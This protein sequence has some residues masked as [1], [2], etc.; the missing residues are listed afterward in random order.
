MLNENKD[1]EAKPLGHG[2]DMQT[3]RW[4]GF[5]RPGFEER[6]ALGEQGLSQVWILAVRLFQVTAGLTVTVWLIRS[7]ED[8]DEAEVT[9]PL[10]SV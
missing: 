2:L 1:W 5:K 4:R 7:S 10:R 3:S 8:P 9:I 6:A